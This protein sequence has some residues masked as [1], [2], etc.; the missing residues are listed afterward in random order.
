MFRR[1]LNFSSGQLQPLVFQ[2]I[3]IE[4]MQFPCHC[5]CVRFKKACVRFYNENFL[6]SIAKWICCDISHEDRMVSMIS[7]RNQ[8]RP[9]KSLGPDPQP[10]E[11]PAQCK[12]EKCYGSLEQ[13]L[14][15]TFLFLVSRNNAESHLSRKSWRVEWWARWLDFSIAT[16]AKPAQK[17]CMYLRISLK[18]HPSLKLSRKGYHSETQNQKHLSW[19]NRSCPPRQHFLQ[20]QTKSSKPTASSHSA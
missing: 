6:Q 19:Q 10:F 20:G 5:A 14:S 4:D 16:W 3:I 7:Q 11:I 15:P 12:D 8:S 13:Q 18:Y 2:P 1:I 9:R 17:S